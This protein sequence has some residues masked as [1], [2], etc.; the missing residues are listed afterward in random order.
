MPG[1]AIPELRNSDIFEPVLWHCTR[2]R[3]NPADGHMSEYRMRN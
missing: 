3:A 2:M 1:I